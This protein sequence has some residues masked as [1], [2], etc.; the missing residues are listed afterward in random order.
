[1]Y[2]FAGYNMPVEYSGILDE[3]L[4]VCQSV[5]VFDVSHMGE[6]WVKGPNALAFLQ[7]VTTNDLSKLQIGKAQYTCFTNEKGG[8]IDDLLVYYYEAD[9]YMLVVNASNVEKDWEWCVQNNRENAVLENASDRMGQ[10]AVQ[11]PKAIDTI[12]KFT[13]I[14]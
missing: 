2:E 9:K 6:I 10:L 4:A 5:G 8:I 3:H 1:M 12:Q 11:G 14:D 7:R 13:K